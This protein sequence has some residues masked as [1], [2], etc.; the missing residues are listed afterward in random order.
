MEYFG[1]ANLDVFSHRVACG[2]TI[3]QPVSGV[4]GVSGMVA[5]RQHRLQP[6]TLPY[7]GSDKWPL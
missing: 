4:A 2:P 6:R 3:D 1:G 7:A 5:R